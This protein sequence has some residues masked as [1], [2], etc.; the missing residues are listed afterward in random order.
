[1]ESSNLINK[2]SVA[3]AVLALG[4]VCTALSIPKAVD[5]LKPIGTRMT[6]QFDVLTDKKTGEIYGWITGKDNEQRFVRMDKLS[7][8]AVRKEREK[9]I[10]KALREEEVAKRKEATQKPVEPLKVFDPRDVRSEKEFCKEGEDNEIQVNTCIKF[11]KRENK[12]LYK[13]VA[14]IEPRITK[15]SDG[16]P[17]QD[18]C[19]TNDQEAKLL[20]LQKTEDN[21][22]KFRFVDTD[23]FWLQDTNIPLSESQANNTFANKVIDDYYLDDCGKQNKLVFHGRMENFSLT[24]LSWVDDGK[25]IFAGATFNALKEKKIK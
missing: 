20:S 21:F 1:M 8:A 4:G 25:L 7:E 9:A 19:I 15:D 18:K 24:E 13:L 3:I 2:T 12:M 5:N 6:E 22:I 14:K 11:R 17:I 23:G 10:D 16:K